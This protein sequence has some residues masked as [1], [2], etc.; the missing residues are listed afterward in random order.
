MSAYDLIRQR[1]NPFTERD[2]Q[3]GHIPSLQ[4]LDHTV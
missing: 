2:F 1:D 4:F 3:S